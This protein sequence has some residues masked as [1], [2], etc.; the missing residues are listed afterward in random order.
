MIPRQ[1]VIRGVEYG[2]QFVVGRP[3][4]LETTAGCQVEAVSQVDDGPDDG[5]LFDRRT[6]ASRGLDCKLKSAIWV[7]L[8]EVDAFPEPVP[9]V[10]RWDEW[11][12][13]E[14]KLRDRRIAAMVAKNEGRGKPMPLA[15]MFGQLTVRLAN[16]RVD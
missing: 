13:L 16:S 11:L 6:F 15:V 7:C 14:E 10:L 9:I 2:F 1:G 12:I 3:D 8:P 4:L 5:R